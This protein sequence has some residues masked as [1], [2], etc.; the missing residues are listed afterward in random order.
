MR[1]KKLGAFEVLKF[2]T[3]PSCNSSLFSNLA[4]SL[5]CFTGQNFLHQTSS[6]DSAST[7]ELKTCPSGHGCGTATY[8]FSYVDATFRRQS[9]SVVQG[10]C[11]NYDACKASSDFCQALRTRFRG[12]VTINSCQVNFSLKVN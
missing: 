9:T 6:D 12:Q 11:T 7:V 2:T 5:H 8:Q 4:Y 3:L 1:P 10:I